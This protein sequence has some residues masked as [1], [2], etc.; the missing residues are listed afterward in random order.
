MRA[1]FFPS[2]EQMSEAKAIV[3]SDE[4]LSVFAACEWD[5]LND[6]GHV[7]LAAI[8]KLAQD[9]ARGISADIITLPVL[10]IKL[11]N[12]PRRSEDPRLAR[13]NDNGDAR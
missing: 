4:V 1:E 2:Q 3:N 6:D 13:G 10:P 8:V 9:R 11:V 7:W 12:I 5:E